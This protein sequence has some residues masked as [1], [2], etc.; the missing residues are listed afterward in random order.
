MLQWNLT[1]EFNPSPPWGEQWA[2]T[3]VF[4][5]QDNKPYGSHKVLISSG[6]DKTGT[7]L[8][9]LNNAVKG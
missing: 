1:S 5:K 3:G 8:Q 4:N 9:T 2:A 7:E 6:T